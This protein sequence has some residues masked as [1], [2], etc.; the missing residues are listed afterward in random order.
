LNRKLYE[1]VNAVLENAG[2][3]W[4]RS[5]KA[6]VFSS[7]PTLKIQAAIETEK[8][9]DKKKQYQFF[10]TPPDV[11]NRLLELAE[12]KYTDDAEQLQDVLEPSAGLGAIADQIDASRCLFRCGELDPEK[13]K[14]LMDK[15][16][17]VFQGDFLTTKGEE[18][19]RIVM[20]PPFAK[21]QDIDHVLH[22]YSLLRPSGRVVSV[23]SPAFTFRKNKKS[24]EFKNLVDAYGSYEDVPEGAFKESGTNVRTVIVVL[25][26]PVVH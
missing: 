1:E 20:N 14:V 16:Y 22:A 15:G 12:I 5:A 6:H 10:E 9:V 7:D 24:T 19:D 13:A 25:N 11:V 8:T 17:P 18:F 26:K 21:Q 3:K 4:N 2:G 23:M